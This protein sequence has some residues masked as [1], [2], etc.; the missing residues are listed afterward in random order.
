MCVCVPIKRKRRCTV[1]RLRSLVVSR[2]FTKESF[3]RVAA[4]E[5]KVDGEVFLRADKAAIEEHKAYMAQEFGL[6]PSSCN[7]QPWSWRAVLSANQ[8]GRIRKVFDASLVSSDGVFLSLAQDISHQP[9]I[10]SRCIPTLIRNSL[11]YFLHPDRHQDRMAV[12]IEYYGMQMFPV[13]LP[14]CHWAAQMKFDHFLKEA[15]MLDFNR[16]RRLCGNGMCVPAIGSILA[17]V[18]TTSQLKGG[19]GI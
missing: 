9:S 11:I 12:P 7:G 18:L 8:M 5:L 15:N 2:A 3:E 14:P 16:A 19:N 6:M 4:S 1:G 17:F 13:M 10:L